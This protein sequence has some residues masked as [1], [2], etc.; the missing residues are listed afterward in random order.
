MCV[1]HTFLWFSFRVSFIFILSCVLFDLIYFNYTFTQIVVS[2]ILF[3]C[4]NLIYLQQIITRVC[5]Y[6]LTWAFTASD[7]SSLIFVMAIKL[8]SDRGERG[9]E[10][11][12]KGKK[13]QNGKWGE[14]PHWVNLLFLPFEKKAPPFAG[15]DPKRLTAVIQVIL[16]EKGN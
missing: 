2:I 16:R 11:V 1:Q 12:R 14:C 9:W 8:Q 5:I 6:P 4:K 13:R 3:L 10:W 7:K 15:K